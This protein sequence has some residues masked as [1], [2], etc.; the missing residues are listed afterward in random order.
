MLRAILADPHRQALWAL[1]ILLQV[2][3]GLVLVGE[4]VDAEGLFTL[5]EEA[6]A[7]L[8][9][10]DKKLLGCQIKDVVSNLHTLKPRPIVIVM[11]ADFEDSRMVLSAGAD[12]FV[13]K[14]D[15]PALLLETLRHYNGQAKNRSLLE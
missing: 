6:A 3:P 2:E 13:S 4:A 12:A 8:V 5:A 1:K 9:V 7:D 15:Q 14:T 10:V 11:S